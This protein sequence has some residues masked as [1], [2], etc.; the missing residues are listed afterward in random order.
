MFEY[1]SPLLKAP[2]VPHGLSYQEL[3]NI[4]SSISLQH[5]THGVH[6]PP[7]RDLSLGY[8]LGLAHLSSFPFYS[9][10][11]FSLCVHISVCVHQWTRMGAHTC[12]CWWG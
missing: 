7:L 3:P 8:A 2:Q 9:F 6:A 12:M 11:F 10:L 1:D 5:P 4:I